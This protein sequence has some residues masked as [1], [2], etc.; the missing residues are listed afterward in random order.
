MHL[1][2]SNTDLQWNTFSKTEIFLERCEKGRI[3]QSTLTLSA[4]LEMKHPVLG[5]RASNLEACEL[6]N[7]IVDSQKRQ[8]GI[9]PNL[10]INSSSSD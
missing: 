1:P 5:N 6:V 8:S 4:S 9:K 7:I 10:Y 2:D 3:F